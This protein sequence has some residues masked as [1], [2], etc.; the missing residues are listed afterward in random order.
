MRDEFPGSTVTYQTSGGGLANVALLDQGRVDMGLVTTVELKLATQGA[1]PFNKEYKDLR[2]LA[3]LYNWAPMHLFV[4]S[5]FAKEYGITKFSDISEKKAP[6]DIAF[7]RRGNVS[8]MVAEKM[9]NALGVTT[10]DIESWG[11]SVTLTP[12][13]DQAD[14]MR[15]G[16]IDALL[17]SDFVGRQTLTELAHDIDV[18]VLP[19][20]QKVI[21]KVSDEMGVDAVDIPAGSYPGQ[22]EAIHSVGLGAVLVTTTKM[23]DGT[24]YDITK[25]ILDHIDAIQ[26]VHAAMKQLTP[27]LVAGQKAIPYHDGSLK[28]L[29]EAGV[30]K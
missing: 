8:S 16:R 15:D 5:S 11:G 6:I 10:D 9:F 1:E 18:K 26:G 30:A 12:A 7:N 27:E 13:N 29:R 21:D 22:D 28:A 20:D 25:S 14:L 24:A 23:D 4:S 2:A 17:N 19:I 3:Y